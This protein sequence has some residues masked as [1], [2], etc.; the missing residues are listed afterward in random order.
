MFEKLSAKVIMVQEFEVFGEI[1][2]RFEKYLEGGTV[3]VFVDNQE[4]DVFTNYE[5]EQNEFRFE[6]ACIEYLEE[7]Y[8]AE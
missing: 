3:R 8:G 5:I 7:H 6:D 4:V 2:V 1:E